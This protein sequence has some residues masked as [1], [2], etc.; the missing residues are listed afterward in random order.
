ML[1]L[2]GSGSTQ[3][4]TI[5]PNTNKNKKKSAGERKIATDNCCLFN[6]KFTIFEINAFYPYAIWKGQFSQWHLKENIT[7]LEYGQLLSWK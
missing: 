7:S 3:H 6:V 1:K 5:S 2:S 4:G